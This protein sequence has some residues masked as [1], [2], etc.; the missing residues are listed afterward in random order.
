MSRWVYD[1]DFSNTQRGSALGEETRVSA[2]KSVWDYMSEK[3][4]ERLEAFAAAAKAGTAPAPAM[5]MEAPPE[6]PPQRA[7]E[8]VIPPL[9]PRTASAALQGY[10]PYV[11]DEYKQERYRSYLS[12]QT[13]NTKNPNPQLLPSTNVDE[14]N[15]ELESFAASARIF[16]PMSI[17]MSS[18]FTSGS[19][20]LAAADTSQPKAGLHVLDPSKLMQFAKPSSAE[21]DVQKILSP[22]EQAAADGQFGKLTREVREFYPAKLVCR[23]FHVADPHPE[24]PPENSGT[25]T[26]KG[27]SAFEVPTS[28]TSWQSSFV[29]QAGT[30]KEATPESEEE[31]QQPGEHAPR[32]ITEVGMAEDANQGRDTLTYVKPSIDIFKAIFASDDEDDDDDDKE[33]I[34]AVPSKFAVA[35]AT[36]RDPYPVDEKPVD[37]TTFKPVFR[38]TAEERKNDEEKEK[39]QKK[40][41][42]KEKKKRKGVLSFDVGDEGEEPAFEKPKKKS[43]ANR[44]EAGEWV[45]KAPAQV[46]PK[47]EPRESPRRSASPTKA[48]GGRKGAADLW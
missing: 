36:P 7:T 37:Y 21:V 20:S 39:A 12:S 45:E 14:V 27:G 9:S 5:S 25:S 15:Q 29:H 18:R 23:R 33:D 28:S 16:K 2:A 48:R 35:D 11:D 13:Y 10:M 17:A 42:K 1:V 46:Q 32:S 19:A 31:E 40:K 47:E 30:D 22:R 43:K 34:P 3:D 4:R 24:G 26:P 44:E 8:V 41:E 38:R 6:L